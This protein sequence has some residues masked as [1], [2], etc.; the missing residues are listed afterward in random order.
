LRSAS[1]RRRRDGVVGLVRHRTAPVS[2]SAVADLRAGLRDEV[3]TAAARRALTHLDDKLI[4]QTALEKAEA[5]ERLAA[6]LAAVARRLLERMSEREA[7]AE[8]QARIVNEAIELLSTDGA[9][10]EDVLA[11]PPDLLTGIREPAEGLGAPYLPPRPVIPL[12]ANELLV[13]GHGQPAI[14]QQL[15]TELPSAADVDLLVSFVM[16]TGVR[17]LLDEL[18]Q[19]VRRGGCLRVITTTYM[20]ATQPKALNELARIG[21]DVRVAYDADR[22]KLHAKAWLLHRPG[23]LTTGVSRFLERL[24]HCVASGAR[25]EC[26][27]ERGTGRLA[28]RAHARDVRV[29]LG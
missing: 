10:G 24:V 17:T 19:V 15:R 5:P 13:N 28:G 29:V 8:E 23:G 6:H 27:A 7:P 20:G 4:E 9:V 3:L 11:L 16:W 2:S 1:A 12:S 21:A 18:E 25:V 22:T 14:G 26:P